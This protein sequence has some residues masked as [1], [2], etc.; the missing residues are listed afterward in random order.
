[1]KTRL[2]VMKE[3]ALS[4]NDGAMS[5]KLS[6]PAARTLLLA[7]QGFRS[8]GD[9]KQTATKDD[10]LAAIQRMEA[11]QID[12]INVVARSPYLVLWSR[13]GL[14]ESRWLN[15]LLAEGAIFEYWS[16][17]ACF[18]PIADY[19]LYRRSMIEDHPH[20]RSWVAS[21]PDDVARVMAKLHDQG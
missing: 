12:T 11:L 3:G 14:Y 6:R 17:A 5:L 19:R 4:L 18:L 7:A 16:H 8:P 15:E 13:L 10:V 20:A 1:M 9:H 21:H 2:P